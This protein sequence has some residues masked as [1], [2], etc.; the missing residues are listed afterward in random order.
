MNQI[1]SYIGIAM[2]V[3]IVSCEETPTIERLESFMATE[4]YP[5]D[6]YLDTVANKKALIVVAHDDD[7]CMIA[8][9]VA[10]LT[11]NGWQI[12]QLSLVRHIDANTGQNPASIICLGNELILEDGIYRHDLDT[13]KSPYLPIPYDEI[14]RQFLREKVANALVQKINAFQ[15]SVIFTLD[16]Q[17]GGYGHP[18]HIFISQLVVDLFSTNEI[19]AE[20]IYQSVYTDHMEHTIV[21]TWL[22]EKMVRWGYPHAS[23]L[24][25]ELYGIDGMPEPTVEVNIFSAAQTKMDY[26]RGYPE[27][28]RKNL[29]KFIPYYEQFDAE[30]YFGVFDREFFRVIE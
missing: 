15:P 19:D 10:Q 17:K 22:K 4:N 25:N 8:G 23:D 13:M 5:K 30:I 1:L 2:A 11:A 12:K 21:D 6:T 28:A 29:R 14:D 24:A 16:N 3:L 9:T 18:E 27:K 26:L 7:D 20:R